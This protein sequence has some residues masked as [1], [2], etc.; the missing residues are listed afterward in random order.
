ME[1]HEAAELD[2]NKLARIHDHLHDLD[3]KLAYDDFGRGQA[4]LVELAD[5]PPDYI[6][7]D[8]DLVKDIDHR[9]PA[10]Q[11]LVRMFA[12]YANDDGILVI[13]EGVNTGGEVELCTGQGIDLVHGFRFGKPAERMSRVGDIA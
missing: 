6:K 9:P 5:V 8:M 11:Q 10:S 4:R 12:D 7:L 13:A 3:I 2:K 1:V